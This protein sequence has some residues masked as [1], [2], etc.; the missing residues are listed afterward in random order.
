MVTRPSSLLGPEIAYRPW[1]RR[2]RVG[3]LRADRRWDRPTPERS[4]RP[5][6]VAGLDRDSR[7]GPP[8]S[9][10]RY[11]PRQ[12]AA[13][14][15]AI[16]SGDYGDAHPPRRNCSR[17][18]GPGADLLASVLPPATFATRRHWSRSVMVAACL[19]RIGGESP[20]IYRSSTKH[21]IPLRRSS[22]R[23]GTCTDRRPA[24]VDLRRRGGIE[25]LAGGPGRTVQRRDR[26]RRPWS[27]R[28]GRSNLGHVCSRTR[29]SW[30]S[31]SPDSGV[32][33]WVEGRRTSGSNPDSLLAGSQR[34]L[35]GM[36]AL[37]AASPRPLPH[38]LQPGMPIKLPARSRRSP[39]L[40]PVSGR[41]TSPKGCST[42]TAWRPGGALRT[43]GSQLGPWQRRA[44]TGV[45]AARRGRYPAAGTCETCRMSR[46]PPSRSTGRHEDASECSRD[47]A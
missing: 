7:R 31:W 46:L 42:R 19:R 23:S 5:L 39:R 40:L 28:P 47:D 3:V 17:T 32:L 35:V 2:R 38:G 6:P 15:A 33:R 26:Y 30:P 8:A 10:A 34:R 45:P 16:R 9:V 37:E 43:S 25:S 12:A 1:V 24:A 21:A 14:L 27:R 41:S 22:T 20:T 11:G 13:V 4:V 18:H 36:N 29:P 44:S